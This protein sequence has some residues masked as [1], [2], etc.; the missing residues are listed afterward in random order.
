MSES[1]ERSGDLEEIK[2]EIIE[3]LK[4]LKEVIK[5]ILKKRNQ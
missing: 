4:E 3:V 5:L 2:K 1:D